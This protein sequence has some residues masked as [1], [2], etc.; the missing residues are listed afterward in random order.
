MVNGTLYKFMK[1]QLAILVKIKLMH[2]CLEVVSRVIVVMIVVPEK[3]EH[4]AISVTLPEF[5]YRNMSIIVGIK[6]NKELF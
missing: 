6:C 2:K 4:A 5:F 1:V 3:L